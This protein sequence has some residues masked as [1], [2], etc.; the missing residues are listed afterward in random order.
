MTGVA[1]EVEQRVDVGDG[2]MFGPRAE[3][4]DVVSGLYLAL[5]EH[6]EVEAWAVVGDEQGGNPRIV[7]ADPDAIAGDARL[8]DFEPCA[9]DLKAIADANGIVR[10]SFNGK[11]LTKM[12]VNKIGSFQLLCPVAIGLDL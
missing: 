8:G 1:R 10:P 5:L 3:L 6:P 11:V 2:H 4:D 12:P 7:H 9:A